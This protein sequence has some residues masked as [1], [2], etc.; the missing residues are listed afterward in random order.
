MSHISYSAFKI[1]NE[2]PHKHKLSYIDRIKGF[3]GNEYTAFGSALHSV[4]EHALTDETLDTKAYFQ[5]QFLEELKS[6]PENILENL[7]KKMIKEMRVQGDTLAPLAIPAL[8][9]HFGEIEV[10]SVEEQLY[11]VIDETFNFKGFIDLVIK[12]PDGKYHILDW[13]TCGWGWQPKRKSDAMTTYQLTFYKH[14]FAQKHNVDPKNI[15]TYF[16]LLKRTA[17]K[18][19]VEIFKVTSGKKKTENA[20][21]LLN[22]A[23]HNIKKDFHPKNRSSCQTPFGP[24]EFF[25]TK[26]CT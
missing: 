18:D 22:K 4:C 6:L 13:K 5:S 9:E 23:L 8:R 15:E 3:E 7:N 17:K 12:T 25:N 21:N 20:L 11:E 26:H 16:A 19:N 1:W 10:I 2:C 24:C 14:Y